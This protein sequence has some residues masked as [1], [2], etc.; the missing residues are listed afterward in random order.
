MSSSRMKIRFPGQR[1]GAGRIRRNPFAKKLIQGVQ[2]TES[3]P[4]MKR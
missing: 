4:L 1:G 2:Y 3:Y